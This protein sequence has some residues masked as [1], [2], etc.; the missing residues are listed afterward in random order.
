[1]DATLKKYLL[2]QESESLDMS[3][4]LHGWH[5]IVQPTCGF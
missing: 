3:L 2:F 4:R 5:M 1:M